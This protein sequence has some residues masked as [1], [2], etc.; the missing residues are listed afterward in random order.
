MSDGDRLAR[1]LRTKLQDVGRQ[2]EEARSEFYRGMYE[3][4]EDLPTDNRGRVKLVCRRH[5][6][7]RAVNIDGGGRPACYDA[8]HPDCESC[9]EDIEAD[10]I[11]TW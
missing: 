6:E 8:D 11:E 10:R 2:Y 4:P 7:K 9:V 1:F 3:P 5:A